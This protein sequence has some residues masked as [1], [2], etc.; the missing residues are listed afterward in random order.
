MRERAIVRERSPRFT[1]SLCDGYSKDISQVPEQR[2]AAGRE[3]VDEA[4]VEVPEE[5]AAASPKK[6]EVSFPLEVEQFWVYFLLNFP[7]FSPW[8]KRIRVFVLAHSTIILQERETDR[9]ITGEEA[10]AGGGVRARRLRRGERR[11]GEK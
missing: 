4:V 9:S 3:A 6:A 7:G 10:K 2:A 8:G 1:Y 5:A 11:R